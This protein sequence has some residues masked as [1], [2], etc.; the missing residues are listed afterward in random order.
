MQKGWES[1]QSEVSADRPSESFDGVASDLRALRTS[2]GVISY[3]EIVRRVAKHRMSSG[4]SPEASH[5]ARSTVYD[6]FK[7]GRSRINA[8]LVGEIARA[9]GADEPEVRR[10]VQRCH[11]AMACSET[12]A[13]V[14]PVEGAS[15]DQGDTVPGPQ[16]RARTKYSLRGVIGIMSIGIALN[17]IGHAIV[18]TLHLSLYLDMV[19]TAVVAILLGPWCG[20]VVAIFGSTAGFAV[21]GAV[22]LPFGFVNIAGALVWGYG[23]RRWRLGTSVPRFFV[24]NLLVAV[25]CTLVAAPLL[26]WGFGGG[27]GHAADGITQTFESFGEPLSLAVL[28]SNLFTSTA[29]KLLTGFVA[30]AAVCAVRTRMARDGSAGPNVDLP[31]SFRIGLPAGR[32]SP[33]V[34]QQRVFKGRDSGGTYIDGVGLR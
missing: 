15:P 16:A 27:T 29:D 1:V 5:P 7:A 6:A 10:W 34:L 11:A 24:L 19:G 26:V 4:M 17:F 21:H 13:L 3:A 33:Q 22:A 8:E 23:I 25:S 20:A 31:T 18:G 12:Q 9:L 28:Q 14:H 30:L 32:F 2:A